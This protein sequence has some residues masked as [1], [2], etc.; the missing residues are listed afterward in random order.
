MLDFILLSGRILLYYC[1]FL[2]NIRWGVIIYLYQ[3]FRNLKSSSIL[4]SLISGS[5]SQASCGAELMKAIASSVRSDDIDN[6]RN[7]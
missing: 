6:N 5:D 7:K 4:S 1:E 2:Q 3:S